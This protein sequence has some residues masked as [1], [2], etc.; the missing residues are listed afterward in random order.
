MILILLVLGKGRSH[1]YSCLYMHRLPLARYPRNRQ[2]WLPQGRG[3]GGQG[4]EVGAASP[5]VYCG[6][7]QF[8]FEKNSVHLLP[9]FCFNEVQHKTNTFLQGQGRRT[10]EDPAS[11]V[12]TVYRILL[13]CHVLC[14][15]F[16]G[17][18]QGRQR[19]GAGGLTQD[20]GR[21]RSVGPGFRTEPR[22]A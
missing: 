18:D 4:R 16:C 8:V 13:I 10:W 19:V 15:R 11:C 9:Y 22:W 21:Q 7:Q 1:T 20:P 3:A 5:K 6:S 12:L 17:L 14:P 2:Q